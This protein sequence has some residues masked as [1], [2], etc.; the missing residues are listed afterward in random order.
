MKPEI[1]CKTV[2]RYFVNGKG[3]ASL[4]AACHATATKEEK[5]K[6]SETM[7]TYLYEGLA[8]IEMASKMLYDGNRSDRR[9]AYHAAIDA[10]ANQLMDAYMEEQG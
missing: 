10:R 2:K 3:Y 6:I 4:W 7:R 8:G 1:K 5:E 9:I